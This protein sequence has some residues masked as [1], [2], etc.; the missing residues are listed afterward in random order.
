[1]ASTTKSSRDVILAPVWTEKSAAQMEENHYTF[2][3]A[4]AA[5]KTQVKQAVEEIWG[6]RVTDVRIMNS[7]PRRARR[8]RVQGY[9]P[10]YKKAVVTLAPGDK[11]TLFEGMS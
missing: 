9:R 2:R 8:G 4:S 7:K 3:V 11:I 1:M 5:H 10:G 6:V